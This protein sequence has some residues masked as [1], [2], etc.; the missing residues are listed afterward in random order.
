MQ[1]KNQTIMKLAQTALLAALCFVSFTFFQIKIPMP[2]GDATSIHIGNAFCVLAALLLGGGYGG[3]AGAVGMTIADLMDPI[4]IVG[5]PK[6]FVLKL[7]IGLIVGLVAHR[8]A[9]IGE[10]SNKK[11][12]L[13]WSTIASVCGLGFNVIFDPLAGYFYKQIILGQP[14]EMASVLAK[15]STATTFVNAVVSTILVAVLYSALRPALGKAGLL[16][17]PAKV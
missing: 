9:K 2:G 5:A 3:L 14:Q 15:W 11:Y 10:T 8:I 12:I 16:V 17:Q 7:C 4:Y 6:T 13:K 1:H